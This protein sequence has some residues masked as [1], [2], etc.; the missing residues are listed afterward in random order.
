MIL[1]IEVQHIENY[2]LIQGHIEDMVI[3]I[4]RM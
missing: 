4:N 1:G 2:G 3:Q